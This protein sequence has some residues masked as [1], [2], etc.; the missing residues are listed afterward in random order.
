[1]SAT[2]P[3][4]G[5]DGDRRGSAL[6]V[7]MLTAVLVSGLAGALVVVL[8]TEEAV[9]ANHRRGVVALYAADGLLAAVVAELAIEPDCNRLPRAPFLHG[10]KT[11]YSLACISYCSPCPMMSKDTL[12]I[13]PQALS[14]IMPTG[15]Q[16]LFA[17]PKY[18][19]T[20]G[21]LE[22]L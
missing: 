20:L 12:Y 8:S 16:M 6:L 17:S 5:I 2:T 11:K 10:Q 21:L 15:K 1:M 18:M 9:E 14:T 4:D 13:K 22:R 19:R 7:T 3:P